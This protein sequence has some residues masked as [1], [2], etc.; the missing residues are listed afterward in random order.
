MSDKPI[1]GII[2]RPGELN[3]GSDV[4]MCFDSYRRAVTKLGGIPILIMPMSDASHEK[5]A[6]REMPP[7]TPEDK[8][9]I[10]TQLKLCDGI[11]LPGGTKIFEYDK[12]IAKY[13]L[14][15]DIPTLGIC[16]G[17]QV[18]GVVDCDMDTS[19]I[20]MNEVE[21]DHRQRFADYVHDVNIVDKDSKLYKILEKDTIRVNSKHRLS[22][23][24]TKDFK[25]VALSEDGLIEGIELDKN[26][27]AVG[28][29][30]HPEDMVSY[31]ENME[32]LMKTFI[33]Y[34]KK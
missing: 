13:L 12:F 1:I 25:V 22:I 20:K 14:D 30:W 5:L 17:M 2:G 8:E 7:L 15:N 6:P 11:I 3:I 24:K 16:M 21:I 23:T 26:N 9:D 19:I 4:M 33:N 34:A 18:M 32:K 10:I 28:V 27:F 29:Q 31:D